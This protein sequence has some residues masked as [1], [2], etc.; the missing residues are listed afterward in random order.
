M[1]GLP[2]VAFVGLLLLLAF[3]RGP[4]AA[5]PGSD[6]VATSGWKQHEELETYEDTDE[7]S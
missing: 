3:Q 1:V 2:I 6:F 4:S 7:Q 5:K